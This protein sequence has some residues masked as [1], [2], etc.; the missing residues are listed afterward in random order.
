MLSRHLG[1][2]PTL[3]GNLVGINVANTTIGPLEEMLE[4]PGYP[5]LYWALTSLP[6]P[7]IALDKG[8]EGEQAMMSYSVFRDLDEAAPMSAAGL[9][10][11]IASWDESLEMGSP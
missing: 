4:Q 11:F 8:M 2:H 5:N 7:L 9:K 10:R 1:E 6:H 3:I